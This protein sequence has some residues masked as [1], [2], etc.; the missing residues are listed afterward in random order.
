MN[1]TPWAP[2]SPEEPGLTD[3]LR[4]QSHAL[5]VLIA[6]PVL[7]GAVEFG[8][9]AMCLQQLEVPDLVLPVHQEL[10]PLP[11]HPNQHTVTHVFLHVA[12]HQLVGDTVSE[13]LALGRGQ[14]RDVWGRGSA[15]APGLPNSRMGV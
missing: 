2:S 14:R 5:H 7:E 9:A 3:V 1:S 4:P 11:V 12:G 13:A 10:R 8:G 15:L 6:K